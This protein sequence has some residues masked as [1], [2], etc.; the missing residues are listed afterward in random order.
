MV[1]HYNGARWYEQFLQVGR[2][3]RAWILLC[4]ALCLLGAS[5]SSVIMLMCIFNLIFFLN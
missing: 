3:Y 4:L 5:A 1:Y 2:L